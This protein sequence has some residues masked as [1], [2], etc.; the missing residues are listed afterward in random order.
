[1]RGLAEARKRFGEIARKELGVEVTDLFSSNESKLPSN[2]K[3]LGAGG[4]PADEKN[5][6]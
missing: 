6:R 2:A 5:Q 1:M 3:E 4:Q